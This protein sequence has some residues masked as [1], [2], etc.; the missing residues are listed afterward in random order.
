MTQ[1]GLENESN[2][3]VKEQYNINWVQTI[4]K[5]LIRR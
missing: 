3:I 5:K 2:V 4:D 1:R